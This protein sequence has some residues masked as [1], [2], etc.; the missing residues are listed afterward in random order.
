MLANFAK[1]IQYLC[2]ALN[3]CNFSI[4]IFNP[5]NWTYMFCATLALFSIILFVP[6]MFT[7]RMA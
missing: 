3:G 6:Q 2:L 5:L 4:P 7:F 1:T